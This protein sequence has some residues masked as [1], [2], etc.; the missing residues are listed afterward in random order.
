MDNI[1]MIKLEDAA[2]AALIPMWFPP[3]TP[4]WMKPGFREAGE[5]ASE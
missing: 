5:F 1:E 3:H 2:K 4:D